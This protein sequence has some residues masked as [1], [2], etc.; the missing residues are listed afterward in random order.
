MS[1]PSLHY[2]AGSAPS[3]PRRSARRETEFYYHSG[4][5]QVQDVSGNVLSHPGGY[6][7]TIFK[8]ILATAVFRC[9]HLILFFTIEAFI[10]T[11][12]QHHGYKKLAIESTLMAS[13]WSSS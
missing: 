12:L 5:T 2:N 8:A 7:K 4:P 1:V 10:V 6:F 11:Y 9:W 3:S 13:S